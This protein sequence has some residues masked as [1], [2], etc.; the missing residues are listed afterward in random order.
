MGDKEGDSENKTLD[1]FEL[2]NELSA[3]VESK[4][5][6][7]RIA[8]KLEQ[9]L[10]DSQVK[11]SKKQ[12]NMLAEKIQNIIRTYS[13]FD[14]NDKDEKQKTGTI[15]K[16]PDAN[17]KMLSD[18]IGKLHDRL[19]NIESGVVNKTDK[20]SSPRIVK[21]E[22]IQVPESISGPVHEWKL[23]PLTKIPS[24]PESVIVLMKWLQFLV[25]KC[26]RSNLPDI[27]DYYV[28]ID[29]ISQ[30]A[31]IDL[32]DYS[33]GITDEGPKGENIA[34]RKATDLPA[35]DHIQSLLFIQKLKGRQFDKHFLERIDGEIS[36]LNRKLDNYRLK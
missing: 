25:D 17:M 1:E 21:T 31:K 22:D 6:P 32:I 33:N 16:T 13:K 29:W 15:E 5:I 23:D 2:G 12:L 24:D 30:D 11:I 18:T 34:R 27:L 28:D 19:N 35:R 10:K 3:L 20:T 26:G 9:K 36:R 8:E 7:E 14:K 4:I